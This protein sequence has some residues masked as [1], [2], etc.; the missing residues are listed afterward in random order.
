MLACFLHFPEAGFSLSFKVDSYNVKIGGLAIECWR[1]FEI[2][3]PSVLTH[4]PPKEE[5]SQT[6]ISSRPE[7]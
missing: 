7:G 5:S 2:F 3:T 1:Q 4:F 6:S